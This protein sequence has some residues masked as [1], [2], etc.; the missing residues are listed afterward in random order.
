MVHQRATEDGLLRDWCIV[1][2]Q[3]SHAISLTHT[4]HFTRDREPEP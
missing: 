1:G 2:V 3:V 4:N